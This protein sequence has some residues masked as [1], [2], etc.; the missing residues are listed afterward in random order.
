MIYRIKGTFW[1]RA[2]LGVVM[3]VCNPSTW[4][5]GSRGLKPAGTCLQIPVISEY[6]LVLTEMLGPALFL[7]LFFLFSSNF[8]CMYTYIH[9][10]IHTYTQNEISWRWDPILHIKSVSFVPYTYTV[11]LQIIFNNFSPETKFHGMEFSLWFHYLYISN[12]SFQISNVQTWTVPSDATAMQ[13]SCHL[14]I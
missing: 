13:S 2:G 10:Y 9:T 14:R 5:M 4:K 3:H 7:T 1:P 8:T 6:R 11:T 12:L